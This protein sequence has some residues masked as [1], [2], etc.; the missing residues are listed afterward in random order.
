MEYI[1]A[2]NKTPETLVE[3]LYMYMSLFD[4]HYLDKSLLAVW[5][6]KNW[7]YFKKYNIPKDDFIASTEDLASDRILN[8]HPMN[9]G[10]VTKAQEEIMQIAKAQRIYILIA[11]KN[12][13]EK[14][15]TYNIKNKIGRSIDAVFEAPRKTKSY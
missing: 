14:Q 1:L 10:S 5:I 7:Q 3:T 15:A 4:T 2:H 8:A 13:L 9:I 11:F 12:S 6:G